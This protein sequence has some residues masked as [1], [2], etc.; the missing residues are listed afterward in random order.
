M[1]I[2]KNTYQLK[3]YN[4][5]DLIA[6][7]GGIYELIYEFFALLSLYVARKMYEHSLVNT[8]NQTM[9]NVNPDHASDEAGQRE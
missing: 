8:M 5:F 4:V 7:I 3:I 6:Q 9:M 1:E 2:F